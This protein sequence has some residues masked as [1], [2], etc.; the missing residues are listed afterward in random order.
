MTRFFQSKCLIFLAFLNLEFSFDIIK[1]LSK[2]KML[3]KL[4][5]FIFLFTCLIYFT[6]QH[7][8]KTVYKHHSQKQVSIDKGLP[9][10]SWVHLNDVLLQ[11][12]HLAKA[13]LSKNNDYE[14]SDKKYKRKKIPFKWG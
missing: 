5:I 14:M 4:F 2:T 1:K 3:K 10:E 12:F 11:S 6:E 8:K 7:S 13:P 9:L